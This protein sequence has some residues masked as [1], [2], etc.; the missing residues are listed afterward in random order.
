M[1]Q[2]HILY[3]AALIEHP[4]KTLLCPEPRPAA[5]KAVAIGRG[6]AMFYQ[7]HGHDL[8]LKQ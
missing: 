8:V 4:D 6:E 3:D 5:E 1:D 2:R 7:Y